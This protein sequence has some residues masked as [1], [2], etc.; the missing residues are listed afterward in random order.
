MA[1]RKC[2]SHSRR[3]EFKN[4]DSGPTW[5]R[6]WHFIA[7]LTQKRDFAFLGKFWGFFLRKWGKSGEIFLNCIELSVSSNSNRESPFTDRHWNIYPFHHKSSSLLLFPY[8]P[9]LFPLSYRHP[10]L[11]RTRY[12]RLIFS[13]R[14]SDDDPKELTGNDCRT[15]R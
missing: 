10:I 8:F 12:F 5:V 3:F 9:F 14:I 15:S 1:E 11:F 13:E 4:R 7:L 2:V 6:F